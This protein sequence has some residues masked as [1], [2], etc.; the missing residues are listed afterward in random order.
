MIMLVFLL[1]GRNG[2]KKKTHTHRESFSPT[3]CWMC[4]REQILL[5]A[6]LFFPGNLLLW[7]NFSPPSHIWKVS[8]SFHIQLKF[9]PC[10]WKLLWWFWPLFMSHLSYYYFFPVAIKSVTSTIRTTWNWPLQETNMFIGINSVQFSCSVVSDSLRPHESQHARPLCPSLS[11]G[12]HSNSHPSSRWCHPAISSSVV[13]FS[14]CPQPLPASESFPMSQLFAWGG[15][16][17]G[18][19]ALASFLPKNT[20]GWSPLEWTGWISL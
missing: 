15:Q 2:T 20:Q 8:S 18:V 17:T 11:S 7:L 19:S 6:W 10:P 14:S 4:S 5:P 1:G 13:P 9:F 3:T 12:V 16:S